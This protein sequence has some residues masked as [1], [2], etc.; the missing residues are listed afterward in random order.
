MRSWDEEFSVVYVESAAITSLVTAEAGRELARWAA[1]PPTNPAASAT[2][3][4]P[5]ELQSLA[6]AG[7]L[8]RHP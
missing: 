8:I 4:S 2:S 1:A 5:E 6:A 7:L 3:L